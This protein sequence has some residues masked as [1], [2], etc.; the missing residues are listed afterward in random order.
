MN[1]SRI[2]ESFEAEAAR[3]SASLSRSAGL[4]LVIARNLVG[5]HGGH[6]MAT[7]VLGKGTTVKFTLPAQPSP[8]AI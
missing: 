6:I 8:A 4:G 2:V 7:S 3:L 1:S 5:A